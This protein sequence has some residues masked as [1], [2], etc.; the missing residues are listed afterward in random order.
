VPSLRSEALLLITTAF[1]HRMV[2]SLARQPM[3]RV[4]YIPVAN[5]DDSGH[6]EAFY[7]LYPPSICEPTHLEL[8]RSVRASPLACCANKT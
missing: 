2:V 8:L 1:R 3:P 5:G 6:I 7:R 4:C